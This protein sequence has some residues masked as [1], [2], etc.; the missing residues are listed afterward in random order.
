MQ[1]N[2]QKKYRE[3]IEIAKKKDPLYLDNLQPLKIKGYF[4]TSF[5]KKNNF[6][7]L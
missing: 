5:F 7:W 1:K 6:F 2:F 3:F 4:G